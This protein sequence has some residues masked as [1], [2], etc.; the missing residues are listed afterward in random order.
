MDGKDRWYD[1]DDVI[2]FDEVDGYTVEE[3]AKPASFAD[4][5]QAESRF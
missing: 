3:G 1:N 5:A 2:S 4:L